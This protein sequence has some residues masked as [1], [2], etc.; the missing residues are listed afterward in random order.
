[1]L[2]HRMLRSALAAAVVLA[3]LA[4]CASS[5]SASPTGDWGVVA[6]GKPSLTIE[7]DGSFH[8]TDGCNE[9][10]GKGEIAGSAFTFGPFSSITLACEGV[11]PWLNLAV[12]AKVDGDSLVV[13]R[14]DGDTI[15]TLKRR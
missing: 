9:L 6:T 13:Y 3:A 12:T 7:S 11:R 8:G 4:G 15:G 14:G 1:M 10:K 2:S 5:G